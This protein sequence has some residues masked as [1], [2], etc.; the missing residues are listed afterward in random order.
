MFMVIQSIKE[1]NL[2]CFLFLLHFFAGH[3]TSSASD[4]IEKKPL[5]QTAQP[6]AH[7]ALITPKDQKDADLTGSLKTIRTL[8]KQKL[9]PDHFRTSSSVIGFRD[10]SFTSGK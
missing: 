2:H 8:V 9:I 1:V 5:S 6:P 3:Q 4:D 7:Q 10:E